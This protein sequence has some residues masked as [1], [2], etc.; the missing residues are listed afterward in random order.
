[1]HDYN[2]DGKHNS[3]DSS[4]FHN[5]IMNESTNTS[6]SGSVRSSFDWSVIVIL[7]VMEIFKPGRLFDGIFPCLVWLVCLGVLFL[8]FACW[9][10]SK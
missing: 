8:K 7:L 4:I 1:M 5:V 6:P 3:H 2:G 9:L 10:E